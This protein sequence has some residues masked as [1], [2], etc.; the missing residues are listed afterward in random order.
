MTAIV[1]AEGLAD[2]AH[3]FE[4]LPEIASEAAYFALNDTG[5][6]AVPLIKRHVRRQVNFPSGY[7][8]SQRLG[9]TRRASRTDLR[10]FIS[11]RDRP[12]SLARFAPGATQHITGQPE[13]PIFVKVKG[14]GGQQIRLKRA[15]I[16]KLKNGNTGLAI[17]L[18]SGQA[19]D[20]A[21]RPVQLTRNQGKHDGAWLLYGPSVDQVL[22][23]IRKD[24]EDD[25]LE[26]LNSRFIHQF[27]RLSRG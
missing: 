23:N 17:R 2:V 16:V 3:Y 10:L 19:P 18:P 9:V 25:V 8:N 13:R 27:E 22:G 5:R 26:I 7:L 6:D 4:R 14:A 24:V 1:L 20:Q 21:Y 15:F 12:T 11:G